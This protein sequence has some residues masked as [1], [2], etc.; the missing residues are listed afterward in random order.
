MTDEVPCPRQCKGKNYCKRV[1]RDGVVYRC[2]GA[3]AAKLGVT[4]GAVYQSLYKYGNA[5]HCGIRKGIRPGSGKKTHCRPVRVGPHS[6]PSITDAAADLGVSRQ[7][8]TRMLR[9]NGEAVLALVMRKK[10]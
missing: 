4:R 7:L 10:G 1:T 9:G 6:W 8:L 3:L 2:A 5:D